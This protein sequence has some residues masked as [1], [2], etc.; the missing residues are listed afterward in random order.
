MH[1]N[2]LNQV[3]FREK[4][5]LNDIFACEQ[6]LGRKEEELMEDLAYYQGRLMAAKQSPTQTELYQEHIHAIQALLAE[7]YLDAE[8]ATEEFCYA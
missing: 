4:Q 5:L 8:V 6:T 1:F 2:E 7:I 3:S